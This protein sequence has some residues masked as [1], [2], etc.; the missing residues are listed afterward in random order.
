MSRFRFRLDTLRRIREMHRDELRVRLAEAFQAEQ[1]LAA[2]QADLAAEVADLVATRRRLAA[3]GSLD[4]SRLVE[5][6][7]YHL[8]LE[9][10]ARTLAEQAR[11]LAEEVEIRR[12]AMVEADRQVRVL[13]KLRERRRQQHLQAEQ[14]A[15]A[16]RL[17]EVA[18]SRW[19]AKSP[20]AL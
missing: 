13:E 19:E 20:W 11:R 15:D 8:L 3:E 6:Q 12:Q 2:Q 1:I 18:T 14:A 9:A 4:V 17:D 5:S 10:Q 16:K 7:R